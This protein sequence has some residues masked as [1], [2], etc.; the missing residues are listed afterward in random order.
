MP[1]IFKHR[2]RHEYEKLLQKAQI[3]LSRAPE[4]AY[5]ALNDAIVFNMCFEPASQY[6]LCRIVDKGPYDTLFQRLLASVLYLETDSERF[7]ISRSD[8]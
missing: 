3:V 7:E 6:N 5:R 2:P 1:T 8:Q 4:N